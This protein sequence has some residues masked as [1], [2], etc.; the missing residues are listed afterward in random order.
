MKLLRATI[1]TLEDTKYL[2]WAYLG[3]LSEEKF[4]FETTVGQLSNVHQMKQKMRKN[5]GNLWRPQCT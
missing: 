1:G 5:M 3:M 2:K 4:M